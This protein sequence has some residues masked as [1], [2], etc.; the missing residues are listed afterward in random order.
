MNMETVKI[1]PVNAIYILPTHS[2]LYIHHCFYKFADYCL[3]ELFPRTS[4]Q[5]GHTVY[6]DTDGTR[7]ELY[8]LLYNHYVCTFANDEHEV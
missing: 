5:S 6:C 2:G 3:F 7:A 4:V 8:L 1:L